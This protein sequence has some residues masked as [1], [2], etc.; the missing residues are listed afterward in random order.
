M[1]LFFSKSEEFGESK[2]LNL[3]KGTVKKINRNNIVPHTGWNKIYNNG[4]K[5]FLDSAIKNKMF[6]FT[7]SF[8]CRPNDKSSIVG[9]TKYKKF[10][11]CSLIKKKNIIGMQFHPEKSS[12]VGINL[13]KI[14][15]NFNNK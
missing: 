13:L 5:T 10:I 7:H 4:K 1:Q 3:I 9:E 6:Y 15:K 8:Y 12:T 2:G 14:I 11:F